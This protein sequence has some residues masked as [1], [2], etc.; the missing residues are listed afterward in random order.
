MEAN[1]KTIRHLSHQKK[2]RALSELSLKDLKLYLDNFKVKYDKKAKNK[3][4]IFLALR[5]T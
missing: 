5:K 4:L 1:F 3:D 2:L